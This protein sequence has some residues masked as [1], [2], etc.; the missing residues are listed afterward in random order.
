MKILITSDWHFVDTDPFK[1]PWKNGLSTRAKVSLDFVDWLDSYCRKWGII[2]ILHC[3]DMFTERRAI[4][5]PLYN[6]AY[7]AIERLVEGRHVVI[8]PGNH[9]RHAHLRSVHSLHVHDRTL[10]AMDVVSDTGYQGMLAGVGVEIVAYPAGVGLLSP[11]P[12]PRDAKWRLLLIHENLIG[13]RFP[14]GKNS[15]TG[16]DVESL[17]EWMALHEVNTCFCGDI[18]RP[19]VLVG[20]RFRVLSQTSRKHKRG[21]YKV[22][23]TGAPYQMDFGD[24]GQPRGVWLFNSETGDSQFVRYQDGPE[25]V[26]VT[27]STLEVWKREER[28]PRQRVMFSLAEPGNLEWVRE[29]VGDLQVPHQV[30]P[31]PKDRG[32]L[33]ETM[34]LDPKELV[35]RYVKQVNTDLDRDRLCRTG[36]GY[37]GKVVT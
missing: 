9:D 18:H 34:I 12:R 24:E 7:D 25:F 36:L 33:S 14:S 1:K 32:E 20:G 17:R 27:D 31:L 3:G 6:A 13:A 37:V 19:Q 4:P 5:V 2:H 8:V 26:T 16:V 10:S 21:R 30:K 23:L 22:V 29:N 35:R 15:D 11:P 28:D